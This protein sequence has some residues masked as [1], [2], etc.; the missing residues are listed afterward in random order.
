MK[1][2][3]TTI[4]AEPKKLALLGGIIVVGL[5]VVYWTNSGSD[6]PPQAAGAVAGS[7][8]RAVPAPA[9]A[10]PV[11]SVSK[12]QPRAGTGRVAE[13]F[14]PSIKPPDGVDISRV[15][16]RLKTELLARLRAVPDV[17]GVRSVFEFYT[18]PAPPP[19]VAAIKPTPPVTAPPPAPP[20]ITGPPPT[21]PIPIKL[22]AVGISPGSKQRRLFFL[23]GE[24]TFMVKENDL[25]RGRYKVL[26]IG[27]LD[28]DVE[29]TVTNKK[30]TIKIVPEMDQ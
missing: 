3:P 23:D 12:S 11:R 7:S 5:G 25:I 9:N 17:G 30:E 28:A 21:P 27:M 20:K 15:D 26:R 22:Y 10:P 6:S 8:S 4:G 13:D 1:A 14:K 29:D 18:P 2:L 19:P 24:D 16:P